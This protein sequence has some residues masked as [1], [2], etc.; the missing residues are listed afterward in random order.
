M[1]DEKVVPIN[2]E[3]PNIAEFSRVGNYE[4]AGPS[5]AVLKMLQHH[6]FDELAVD[7][8]WIE[9][10]IIARFSPVGAMFH[11]MQAAAVQMGSPANPDSPAFEF[12]R[13]AANMRGQDGEA[14]IGIA[15]IEEMTTLNELLTRK[16]KE[17]ATAD[18]MKIFEDILTRH[19][20]LNPR[21]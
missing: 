17:S 19:T 7:K 16:D 8:G 20:L 2:P 6:K 3:I 4:Y 14:L 12:L 15:T 18:V 1:K 11:T 9:L 5:D 21:A 13:T 10:R